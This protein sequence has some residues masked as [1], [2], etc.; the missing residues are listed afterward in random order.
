MKTVSS[1]AIGFKSS[2]FCVVD[3]G[4][5]WFIGQQAATDSL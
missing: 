1:T 4:D 3:V 5:S 2:V